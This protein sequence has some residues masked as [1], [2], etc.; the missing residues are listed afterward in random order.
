MEIVETLDRRKTILEAA[1]SVFLAYGFKRTTMADIAD[2]A[3][4]SRPALYLEFK[5]KADIYRAGFQLMVENTFRDVERA[6]QR[7]GPLLDRLKAALMAGVVTPL[8]DLQQSPFGA[9]LFE[10]KHEIAEDLGQN[11][12][13]RMQTSIRR[14]LEGATASGEINL[15]TSELDADDLARILVSSVEGIKKRM[16]NWNQAEADI[17]R[18]V[19]LM[20]K[21]LV[22]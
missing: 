6:L 10:V 4:I 20:V 22:R 11:W 21:P 5:N 15:C 7:Q 16:S 13:D 14:A 2:A 18:I 3:G 1:K 17:A 12:N 9:E 19:Q 8:K